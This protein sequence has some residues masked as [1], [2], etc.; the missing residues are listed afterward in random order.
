MK[1]A[2]CVLLAACSV[3]EIEDDY[4]KTMRPPL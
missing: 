3:G 4:W 1:L 2:L